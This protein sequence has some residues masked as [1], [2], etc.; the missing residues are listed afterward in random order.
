MKHG[1]IF[2]FILF[3]GSYIQTSHQNNPNQFHQNQLFL[4][5][6]AKE[7]TERKQI[8]DQEQLENITHEGI[9]MLVNQQDPLKII[10]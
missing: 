2:S 1:M 9:F 10:A 7:A 6:I 8:S 3:F 5:L 4:A